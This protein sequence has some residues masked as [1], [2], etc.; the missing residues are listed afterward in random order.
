MNGQLICFAGARAQR[1]ASATAPDAPAATAQRTAEDDARD[2]VLNWDRAR[3][4]FDEAYCAA[5]DLQLAASAAGSALQR[6][7]MSGFMLN[8]D[9]VAMIRRSIAIFETSA[10]RIEKIVD[11]TLGAEE[12][13]DV[14]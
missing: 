9:D 1:A 11:P 8:A 10:V 7:S 2:G 5:A 14:A 6:L 13:G 3:I 12:A 4:R